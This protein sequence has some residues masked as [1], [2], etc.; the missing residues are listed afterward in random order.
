MKTK[1]ETLKNGKNATNVFANTNTKEIVEANKNSFGFNV[2]SVIG[3]AF[4]KKYGK[5]MKTNQGKKDYSKFYYSE[6]SMNEKGFVLVKRGEE[7]L[8][9]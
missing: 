2:L 9:S 1:F 3:D 8:W 4:F 5:D 7:I 6:K